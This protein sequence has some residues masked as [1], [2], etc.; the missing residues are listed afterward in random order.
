MSKAASICRKRHPNAPRRDMGAKN[1]IHLPIT[2]SICPAM[3]YECRKQRPFAENDIQM[4][5]DGIWMP[6]MTFICRKRHMK[7]PRR[8]REAVWRQMNPVKRHLG[9][10]PALRIAQ[11][12]SKTAFIRFRT[13]NGR[14]LA[15]AG[16]K[17]RSDVCHCGRVKDR[18]F[19]A[20]WGLDRNSIAKHTQN[21]ETGWAANPSVDFFRRH[22]RHRNI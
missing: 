21:H 12:R 3:G 8:D 4:P 5:R 20:K 13:E 22:S 17:S 18:I 9:P 10:A 2:T 7:A 6:K 11:I 16:L 14:F 19:K 1:N 15:A